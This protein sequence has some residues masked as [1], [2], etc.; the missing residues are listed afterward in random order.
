MQ[1]A[2]LH[3]KR[4]VYTRGSFSGKGLPVRAALLYTALSFLIA[5]SGRE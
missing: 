2:A 4:G 5:A 1:K 3:R